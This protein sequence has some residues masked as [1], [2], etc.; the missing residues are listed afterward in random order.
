MI[1]SFYSF[2]YCFLSFS[3][4]IITFFFFFGFLYSYFPF[5]LLLLFVFL[6]FFAL[7][8]L[9]L[10]LL[11]GISFCLLWFFLCV[12]CCV[13]LSALVQQHTKCG[14]GWASQSA[15]WR[16]GPTNELANNNHPKYNS[17]AH[18]SHTGTFLRHLAQD[19]EETAP[20]GPTIL[21][22]RKTTQW[23]QGVRIDLSNT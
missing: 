13:V 12:L 10:L 5:T 15:N 20:L 6:L 23:R 19:V 2:F 18:I 14:G 21:L 22:L 4:L 1:S 11:L 9:I 3:P 17:I 7:L 16:G 8:S